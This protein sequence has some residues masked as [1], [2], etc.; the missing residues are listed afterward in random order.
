MKQENKNGLKVGDKINSF[1]G[2]GTFC[3]EKEVSRVSE[4]SC[5]FM[6]NN[7]EQRE[8]W[9]TVNNNI[10]NGLYKLKK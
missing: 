5:F 3:C 2:N 9:N 7:S 8:S 1:Y 6:W 10:K 4:S